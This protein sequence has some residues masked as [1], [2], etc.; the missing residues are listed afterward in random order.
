VS[1]INAVMTRIAVFRRKVSRGT[2]PKDCTDSLSHSTI[3]WHFQVVLST[4]LLDLVG[5]VLA[6]DYDQAKSRLVTFWA[7]RPVRSEGRCVCCASQPMLEVDGILVIEGRIPTGIW[8]NTS[9]WP[10]DPLDG[11]PGGLALV[12]RLVMRVGTDGF[13]HRSCRGS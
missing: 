6:Q 2:Y 11:R 5:P 7:S 3:M 8:N 9:L 10:R 4:L 12:N 1:I 13:V